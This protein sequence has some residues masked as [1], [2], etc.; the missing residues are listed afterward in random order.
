MIFVLTVCDNDRNRDD[1]EVR[2]ESQCKCFVYKVNGGSNI[3]IS[4]N[5]SVKILSIDDT[6]V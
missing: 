1:D 3:F 2:D 5:S 6:S 4:W